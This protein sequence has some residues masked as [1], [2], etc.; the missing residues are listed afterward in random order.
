M[1][2]DIADISVLCDLWSSYWGGSVV[3]KITVEV[4][5]LVGLVWAGDGR[6]R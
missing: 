6:T 4:V 3:G 1:V 2:D 5:T